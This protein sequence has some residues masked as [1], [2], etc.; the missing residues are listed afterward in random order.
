[1][2]SAAVSV[3]ARL[4]VASQKSKSLQVPGFPSSR[5]WVTVRGITRRSCRRRVQ[6]AVFPV[7]FVA[8]RHNLIVRRSREQLMPAYLLVWNPDV[9]SW[10]RLRQDL[11]TFVRNG[12]LPF[13][14]SCGNRRNLPIGS[15]VFLIRLGVEPKGIVG[16]G[17][18][19]NEP[20]SDN[21]LH[22][23]F[24]FDTLHEKPLLSLS[25]LQRMS[26]FHW[27]SQASGIEIPD[28]TTSKLEDAWKKKR[29]VR[30]PPPVEET[31]TSAHYPEGAVVRITV[32]SYERKPA[33]RRDCI[34][35]YGT[36]CCVCGFR[37]GEF[38]GADMSDFIHVHHLKPLSSLGQ[39]YR[40]SPVR[41]LRPVCP[42]CHAVIH[43]KNPPLSIEEVKEQIGRQRKGAPNPALNR[44]RKKRRAG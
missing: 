2:G 10:S 9:W 14:W 1:M 23:E 6:R 20:F 43:S 25:E 31:S 19:V 35:H 32:N 41:D 11:K 5:A 37:F 38:Y 42:N 28:E 36:A 29:G 17:W 13:S 7:V 21:G 16:S 18:T 44:T 34:A 15:R 4:A 12:A 3:A 24:V 39:R 30:L 8:A 33:V 22:V 27:S 40:V 26:D